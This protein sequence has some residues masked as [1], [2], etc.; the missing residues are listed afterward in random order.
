MCAMYASWNASATFWSKSWS[1][2]WIIEPCR[3]AVR[4]LCVDCVAYTRTRALA[5]SG[6]SRRFSSSSSVGGLSASAASWAS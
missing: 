2:T 6:I 1:K 5:G 3:S 4:V